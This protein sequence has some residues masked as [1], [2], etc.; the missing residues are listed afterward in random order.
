MQRLF[1]RWAERDDNLFRARAAPGEEEEQEEAQQ[2][3]TA[4]PDGGGRVAR[5]IPLK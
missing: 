5:A 1:A 3:A 4:A 2:Q